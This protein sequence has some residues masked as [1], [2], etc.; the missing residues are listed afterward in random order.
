MEQIKCLCWKIVK[1]GIMLMKSHDQSQD[2]MIFK[3]DILHESR[4]MYIDGE[5]VEFWNWDV[6]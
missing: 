5:G 6:C 2:Q 4:V 3:L 1:R